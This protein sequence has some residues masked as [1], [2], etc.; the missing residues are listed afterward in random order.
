MKQIIFIFVIVNFAG[1]G[2]SRAIKPVKKYLM[3]PSVMGVSYDSLNIPTT[4]NERLTAWL[5]HPVHKQSDQL[6][7][8]AEPDAGNMSG[9]FGVAQ[10]LVKNI[11]VD[12]LLFDYRGFGTSDSIVID[13]DL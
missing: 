10:A 4:N 2:T 5:C 1:V 6:I 3:T 8:L 13:T 12:V 11:G 9:E 7:I